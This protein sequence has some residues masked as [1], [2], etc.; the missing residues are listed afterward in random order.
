[1]FDWGD[2]QT[3]AWSSFA[4]GGTPVVMSHAWS[5]PNSYQVRAKAKD[6]QSHESGWSDV[7]AVNV[8][9]S[10]GMSWEEVFSA[11]AAKPDGIAWDG[12]YIW[13]TGET[14]RRIYKVN[15][16][17]GAV[18][19]SIPSPNTLPTGL[20]WD[21]SYLWVADAASYEIY[22]LDPSSG[23]VVSSFSAPGTH[24]SCEGLAWDGANLWHTNF[25]DNRVW[26]LNPANGQVL[27]QFTLFGKTGL[28]GVAW[29]PSGFL[30]LSDQNTDSV[31]RVGPSGGTIL[32]RCPA[33][34]T[35]VQGLTVQNVGGSWRLWTCGYYSGTVYAVT[36][37]ALDGHR[38]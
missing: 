33:P 9:A 18:V 26:K 5:S 34:D 17:N 2:G 27:A 11:P 28:T 12:T 38:W 16:A 31:Y 6:D 8:T 22:K 25:V 36:V 7:L 23:S 4:P 3:S 19:S 20:A 21:G 29:H 10:G 32:E 24:Q 14:N 35:V 30:W 15:P 13:L 37:P 1:M